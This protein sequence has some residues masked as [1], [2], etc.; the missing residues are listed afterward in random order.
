MKNTSESPVSL[1][2]QLKILGLS[3]L[4]MIGFDFLLHGGILAGIYTQDSPFLLDL[5]S[6]FYYIPIGYLSFLLL[7]ILL[8]WLQIQLDI[9]TMI[10]GL[11]FGLVTGLLIWG[12]FMM[13]LFSIATAPLNLLIGWFLGQSLEMAIGAG[14]IGA[15]LEHNDLKTVG[16]WVGIIVFFCL[17]LGIILQNIIS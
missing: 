14:V 4:T 5:Q 16:K 3:W 12:S 7:S 17:V 15:C 13:G 1:A 6:A 2:H 11:K 9:R 8:Y 10:D